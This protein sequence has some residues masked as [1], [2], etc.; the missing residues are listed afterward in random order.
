M[1]ECSQWLDWKQ[2]LRRTTAKRRNVLET[3]VICESFTELGVV[4]GELR[5]GG[6]PLAVREPDG[7][8]RE[9]ATPVSNNL[10]SSSGGSLRKEVVG[11]LDGGSVGGSVRAAGENGKDPA[12]CI[13]ERSSIA[14]A[15]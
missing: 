5:S 14:A 13:D 7:Y 12:S 8:G 4:G 9:L 2:A 6:L 1:P 10:A 3:L 11:T 15:C